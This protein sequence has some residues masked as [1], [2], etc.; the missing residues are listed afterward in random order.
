MFKKI[1]N[2]IQNLKA[3]WEL[4]GITKEPLQETP[5]TKELK[6]QELI[7]KDYQKLM[8]YSEDVAIRGWK[9]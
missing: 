8:E 3:L 7:N 6:R 1:K 5:L 9:E 2:F 4:S